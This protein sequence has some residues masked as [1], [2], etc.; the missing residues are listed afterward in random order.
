MGYY[1]D[2]ENDF[3]ETF[4]DIHRCIEHII[5]NYKAVYIISPYL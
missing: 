5:E 1:A 2:V 3:L 4:I